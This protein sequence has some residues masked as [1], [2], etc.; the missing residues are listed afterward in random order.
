MLDTALRSRCEQRLAQL[1][2]PEPFTLERFRQALQ[3]RRGRSLTISAMP[4]LEPGEPSGVWIATETGDHVFVDETARPLHREHIVLHELAHIICDHQ[5]APALS[6]GD[7]AALLPSLSS[8]MV[9]RVLGRTRYTQA[10]EQEA[11]LLATM[12]AQRVDRRAGQHD[13]PEVQALRGRLRSTLE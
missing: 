1:P 4:A 13:D 6:D 8:E 3:A 7:A 9:A 2:L 5:G 12:I 11:E 10:E